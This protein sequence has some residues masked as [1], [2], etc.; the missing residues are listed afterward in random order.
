VLTGGLFL[1]A[2]FLSPLVT[3]VPFE[4]A[5]TALVIVGFLM[6]TGVRQIDWTDYEIG[7]PAFLTIVLM[8]FTYSITN[9]IGAGVVSFVLI[10]A[11]KGKFRDVH[12]L[13]WGVAALFVLYFLRG[14]ITDLI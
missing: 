13:L 4:A 11:A 2:M 7:I 10:K 3:V 9:G 8:P 12:P 5:A 6:M 14:V 1:L